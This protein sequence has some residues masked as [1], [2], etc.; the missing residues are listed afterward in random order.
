M[1]SRS[2]AASAS[3]SELDKCGAEDP[4]PKVTKTTDG[5]V[6]VG[7]FSRP[8]ASPE[9]QPP[10]PAALRFTNQDIFSMRYVLHESVTLIK[11]PLGAGTSID[12]GEVTSVSYSIDRFSVH[13][14][15]LPPL[16]SLGRSAVN[17]YL[18]MLR[19]EPDG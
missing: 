17:L 2:A 5:N 8:V 12:A 14:F 3:C 18:C 11:S 1:L 9:A 16:A 19:G 6:F 10:L 7:L 15:R 13:S 4:V